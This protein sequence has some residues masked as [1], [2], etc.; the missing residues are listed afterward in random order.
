VETRAK[1][2]ENGGLMTQSP[3]KLSG[4]ACLI[5]VA[6]FFDSEQF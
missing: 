1:F 6:K 3:R 5:G 2:P 4:F